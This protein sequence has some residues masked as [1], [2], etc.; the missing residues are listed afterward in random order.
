VQ[1]TSDSAEKKKTGKKTAGSNRRKPNKKP[2]RIQ[3]KHYLRPHRGAAWGKKGPR[4][5]KRQGKK[6]EKAFLLVNN[7]SKNAFGGANLPGIE[8]ECQ[9]NKLGG[10]K[11]LIGNFL[12]ALGRK[13]T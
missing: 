5:W 7:V 11:P 8:K 1:R 4:T 6:K 13:G 9:N 2:I 3:K 12:V 10:K